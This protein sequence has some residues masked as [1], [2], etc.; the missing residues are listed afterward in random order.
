[1]VDIFTKEKRSEVMS[2][3]RSKWTR[4]EKIVH[5]HLKGRKI[6][7]SM[8]PK[9][10]GRPDVLLK[11]SNAL[12]FLDGCFWHGCKKCYSEPKNNKKYWKWKLNYNVNRDKKNRKKLRLLGYKVERV[13]EHDF[14][15]NK[16]GGTLDRIEKM[17]KK[18]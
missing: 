5:N 8:H 13:W 16:I 14:S 9:I 7:H 10:E 17:S 15:K 1:M 12:L 18:L 4:Q 2:K 3:I 6:K 11:N